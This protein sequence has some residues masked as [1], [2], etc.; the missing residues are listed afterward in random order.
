M[1]G[2][3][4]KLMSEEW[5]NDLEDNIFCQKRHLTCSMK[6][7]N[8]LSITVGEEQKKGEGMCVFHLTISVFAEIHHCFKAWPTHYAKG[9]DLTSKSKH[10]R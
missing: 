2:E 1:I 8:S 9:P 10:T 7:L 6:R 3:W 5:D 4:M